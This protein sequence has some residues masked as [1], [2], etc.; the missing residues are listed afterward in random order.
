VHKKLFTPGPV[1]VYPHVYS[2]M[3]APMITHRG[4]EYVKLHQSVKSS[5]GKILGTTTGRIFLFTSSSTGAMEASIRNLV[6]KKVLVTTCGAFSERFQKIAAANGKECEM[7]SVEWGM[8]IKPEMI[9]AKLRSGQFDAMT[10]VHSETSTGV[11]NPLEQ[12]AQTMD[13]FPDVTFIVDAVSSM[14]TKEI[15]PESLGIDLLFAGTQKGFGLP[16]GLTVVYTSERALEKAKSVTNR[17]HYFDLLSFAEFD[18]DDQTPETPAVSMIYALDEQLKRVVTEGP[19]AKY[20]KIRQ[21]ANVCREWACKYFEMFPEKGYETFGLTC[22]K[23]TR[24]INVANLNEELGKRGAT[25][26]EGYGKI[27][28]K[29]FRIAHMAD[30]QMAEL[31]WLLSEIESILKLT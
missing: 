19:S 7:L 22:I 1:E 15:L 18:K 2:A 20:D 29:T 14:L 24:G 10:L 4:P 6:K 27:K 25:I 26:S 9:E 5:L 28:S 30:I 16:P 8:A 3:S 12:I 13:R 11:L 23:N 17:G 21:M 31:K